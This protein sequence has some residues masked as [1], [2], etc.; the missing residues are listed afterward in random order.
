MFKSDAKY[1][2]LHAPALD[3]TKEHTKSGGEILVHSFSNG[4]GNQVAQFMKVWKH[5]E[6]TV[7]PIRTHFLDSSPGKGGWVRSHAAIV[8]SLPPG[9]FWNLFGSAVVHLALVLIFVIDK[10]TGRENKITAICRE[11]NDPA[12]FDIRAPRVYLYSK[13]DQ[14]VGFD[15]VEEHADEGVGKGFDVT[16]VRFEKSAHA[17]HMRE[18]EAKYWGAV[19][20][21]WKRG[22][23]GARTVV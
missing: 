10:T 13:A 7:L 15:D 22:P 23:N 19:M 2:T 5:R 12:F 8:A 16:K 4:G 3:V 6:G 20:E 11:L 14:M 9:W 17:G 18:D 1:R 21:A